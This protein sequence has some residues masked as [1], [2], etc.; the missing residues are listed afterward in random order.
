MQGDSREIWNRPASVWVNDDAGWQCSASRYLNVG[1]SNYVTPSA[2]CEKSQTLSA[3]E[4][5]ITSDKAATS[6]LELREY[7]PNT[8]CQW[9][10]PILP[11]GS[12][13]DCLHLHALLKL[14][15]Q[16][17]RLLLIAIHIN[18]VTPSLHTSCKFAR[19]AARRL[20]TTKFPVGPLNAAK[21]FL[22]IILNR[23][24][25]VLT[26]VC[27]STLQATESSA[28]QIRQSSAFRTD[29][30]LCRHAGHSG[31]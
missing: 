30:W 31:C 23:S 2:L 12:K 21:A 17:V 10:L 16:F 29:S 15:L 13:V 1:Q 26:G 6:A 8:D 27:Y 28:M 9:T 25:M 11:E 7:H 20:T 22:T 5:T 24:A 3:T 4:G 19:D 14:L 18:C